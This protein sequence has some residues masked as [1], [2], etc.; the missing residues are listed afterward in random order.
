MKCKNIVCENETTG[1]RVYC[2]LACRNI[3]VN[4]YL[5]NYDK[6]SDTFKQKKKEKEEKYLENP[7]KCLHC[8]TIIPYDS[9]DNNYCNHSCFA[10]ESNGRRE[11]TWGDKISDGIKRY[12]EKNGYFGALVNIPNSPGRNKIHLENIC[13]NCNA[14]FHKKSKYCNNNC[15]REFE[16]KN[17]DEYQKYRLDSNFKFNLADYSDEFDFSLVSEHGWYSPTNKKNNLGGVSRDHML[18]VREGFEMG[19]DPKII[20][21]P[22]NCRLMIHNDNISKNKKSVITIKELLDRI[23]KFEEMY[24]KGTTQVA[25]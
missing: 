20:S 22:A 9:K 19:I 25:V 5:R 6:V 1:K 24:M 21:H 17:M 12:I 14:V 13:P 4:K 8:D 11:V 16:R 18:S 3:F 15:R 10:S 7:K 2:S 23:E